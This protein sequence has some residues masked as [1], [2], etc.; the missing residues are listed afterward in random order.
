MKLEEEIKQSKFENERQKAILNVI[1]T[2]NWIG[3]VQHKIFKKHKLTSPQYNVLRILR[4]KF[5]DP[6]TVSSIQERMLD[7]MSNASRLVDKL[8]EKGWAERSTCM[9]DRRQVDVVITTT[10]Q[11][12]LQE[13]EPEL[14]GFHNEEMV[15]S[16][17]DAAAVNK[18]LDQIRG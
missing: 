13:I 12:L 9:Y 15:L 6:L 10:G 4:G 11:K 2:A 14:S 16:E 18:A 7:K 3:S 5:P 1:Y 8:V 17:A